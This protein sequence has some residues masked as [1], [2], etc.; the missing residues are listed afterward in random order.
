MNH[1]PKGY[2]A[3]AHC[4]EMQIAPGL[5]CNER[6]DSMAKVKFEIIG[7]EMLEKVVTIS[8]NSGR[9]YLPPAWLGHKVKIVRID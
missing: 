7:I 8:G 4:R 1:E 6:D 3:T 2:I 5:R 9:A